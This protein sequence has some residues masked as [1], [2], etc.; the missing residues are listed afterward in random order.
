MKAQYWQINT[1]AKGF[2]SLVYVEKLL[3]RLLSR[4]F[5]QNSPVEGF[6]IIFF[7]FVIGNISTLVHRNSIFLGPNV[8]V[9]LLFFKLMQKFAN[10][11]F[12][13][14]KAKNICH[15]VFHMVEKPLQENVYYNTWT[16]VE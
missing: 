6:S 7:L 4:W 2:F 3:Y 5:Y 14:L 8:N 13:V 12:H 15:F 1:M 16:K 10:E 9:Y 11:I